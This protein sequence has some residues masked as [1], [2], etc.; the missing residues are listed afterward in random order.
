MLGTLD[1]IVS[2]EAFLE[3]CFNVIAGF[4]G[5]RPLYLD[6]ATPRRPTIGYGFNLTGRSVLEAVATGMGFDL[7]SEADQGYLNE[8]LSIFQSGQSLVQI[9]TQADS[10]M[11]ERADQIVGGARRTFSF[12]AGQVGLAEMRGAFDIA[13]LNYVQIAIDRT[14]FSETDYSWELVALTSLAYNG[15]GGII[16]RGLTNAILTD[17][18]PLAWY[19]IRYRSNAE[20]DFGLQNRREHEADLFGLYA[21]SGTLVSDI[22]AKQ[23]FQLFTPERLTSIAQYISSLNHKSP[24]GAIIEAVT[25]AEVANFLAELQ[26][27]LSP[28]LEFLVSTHVTNPLAGLVAIDGVILVGDDGINENFASTGG[29]LRGTD[30]SDL[31]FG[32]GGVDTVRGGAGVDVAYGG[33][34]SDILYGGDSTD[35]LFGEAD[36][37][38]LHG[39]NGQDQLEGGEGADFLFGGADSDDQFGGGGDDHLYGGTLLNGEHVDDRAIDYF[40]G[41]AGADSIYAWNNDVILNPDASDRVYINGSA[42]PLSLDPANIEAIAGRPG[43]FRDRTSG[44]TFRWTDTDADGSR[45]QLEIFGSYVQ[46]SG[47]ENGD[48]G[49]NLADG[50]PPPPSSVVLATEDADVIG[51]PNGTEAF[52]G[53]GGNDSISAKYI[54][55]VAGIIID[56]GDGDD[57]IRADDTGSY[58]YYHDHAPAPTEDVI[59]HGAYL[60]GGSGNDNLQ[61]SV[62]EDFIDGGVGHD[63]VY[64]YFGDDVVLTGDG[65]DFISGH[66]GEDV[67]FGDAGEDELFGGQGDDVIFGGD[68][69]DRMYGDG[70][71]EAGR[72][73]GAT[74]TYTVVGAYYP[75]PNSYAMFRDVS[76]AESGADTIK[77]GAGIDR[78]YGGAG[79]DALFGGTEGDFLFG[80]VGDDALYG[81][82]GNDVLWG[83]ISPYEYADDQRVLFVQSN[84]DGTSVDI[85]FRRYAQSLD[86]FGND[87]LDG[88]DGDDQI[89]GQGGDDILLGGNGNDFL[90]GD[91]GN[92]VLV[93]GDNDDQLSGDA[94]TDTL[95]GENGVDVLFGGAD[96]DALDGGVGADQLVGGDGLDT[97]NGGDDADVLFGEAGDDQLSGS[98]GNDQLVA[99]DGNDTAAGDGG[100]DVL[101]GDAG[102]DELRGGSGNDQLQGGTGLDS[103]Y[104][105]DGTDILLG[106]ADADSLF[107]GAGIDDL[108]GGA[109]NDQLFG[110]ADADELYG[111]DGDD[112]L[113]GDGGDDLLLGDAGM[114][115]LFGGEGA[116]QLQGAE[117]NDLLD[118]GDGT[119][120]LFGQDGMDV[121][122]GGT[123]TDEMIGGN[124]DD[125]YRFNVGDGRDTI[126][127]SS[128]S[129][130]DVIELGS[131]IS[132]ADVAIA[133]RGGSL[134]LFMSGGNDQ[135]TIANWFSNTSTRV[136]SVGFA[137]GTVWTQSQ[138]SSLPINIYLGTSGSDIISDGIGDDQVLGYEGD[139]TLYGNY[140]INQIVGGTGNDTLNLGY[141]GSNTVSIA[142]GDGNDTIV[143]AGDSYYSV[144][145]YAGVSATELQYDRSGNN[146]VI[147][148]PDGGQTVV[149]GWF[150]GQMLDAIMF[151]DGSTAPSAATISAVAENASRNYAVAADAPTQVLDDWG[152]TDS[153]TFGAGVTP[154]QLTM[155]RQGVDLVVRRTDGGTTQDLVRVPF[156]F[157]GANRQIEEFRFTDSATVFT[158]AA[159]TAQLLNPVGTPSADIF[160][161]GLGYVETLSGVGGN[162]DLTG[163]GNGY[164]LLGGDGDDTLTGNGTGAIDGGN[165][166]DTLYG[167][168]DSNSLR[169]G[170]GND[171]FCIDGDFQ[172]ATGG[173]G[174]DTFENYG[175]Y[176]AYTFN[177]GDGQDVIATHTSGSYFGSGT[178]VLGY[179]FTETTFTNSGPDKILTFAGSSDS[180]R[181]VN[182]V[183]AS[184]IGTFRYT[185]TGT[186]GNDT[187]VGVDSAVESIYGLG[188]DDV[189]YGGD[190]S[191][192][193]SFEVRDS[194]YGGD[195]NDYL[196]GGRE[197]DYLDGGAGN[198]TLGGGSGSQDYEWYGNT[199]RGGAGDDALRGTSFDDIYVYDTG[200]GND[201]VTE[202]PR[203]VSGGLYRSGT[204]RINFG[205]GI[206]P[207]VVT[208]TKSG[209]DLLLQ[210]GSTGS[211]TFRAWFSSSHNQ[212]EGFYFLS[213]G[214]YQLRLTAA[215]VTGMALT[216]IGTAGTDTLVGDAAFG[217]LLYGNGG[218]DTLTGNGGSDYLDGGTGDDTLQGGAGDDI[219]IFG[220]GYGRDLVT[221]EPSDYYSS[222]YNNDEVRF[223]AD[224][225]ASEI[226][227]ARQGNSLLLSIS[228]TSDAL[229]MQDGLT[230][231][232]S[233]IERFVFADGSQLPS[234]DQMIASLVNV[235]GTA[236]DDTLE[237]SSGFDNIRGLEGNDVLR[238]YADND[239]L[240][241]GAGNDSLSGGAGNDTLMGGVGDDRYVYATGDGSDSVQDSLGTNILDFSGADIAS[242][243]V[244][245]SWNGTVNSLT[246]GFASGSLQVASGFTEADRQLLVVPGGA[247]VSFV[248]WLAQRQA[249][250]LVL[251]HAGTD[252]ADQMIGSAGGDSMLGGFGDDTLRGGAGN[253]SLN[254]GW[255][256]DRLEGGTGNDTLVG[257]YG[258]DE[259]VFESGHGLDYV[260]ESVMTEL[261]NIRFGGNT[262]LADLQIARTGADLILLNTRTNDRVTVSGYEVNRSKLP[263]DLYIGSDFISSAALVGQSEVLGTASANTLRG[264]SGSDRIYGLA[265]NDTLE[266][267]AGADLLSGGA[268]NDRLL[269]G[270]GAD[271]YM[272]S[273]G[274]GADTL[275]E[276]GTNDGAVDTVL[277]GEGVFLGDLRFARSGTSLAVSTISGPDGLMIEGWYSNTASQVERFR[278]FQGNVLLNTQVEQ[279]VQAA[280]AFVPKS[281]ESSAS[282]SASMFSSGDWLAASPF[283]FHGGKLDPT[284]HSV[285]HSRAD[286]Y[287]RGLPFG[288]HS[289]L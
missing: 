205:V 207:A 258:V 164:T 221:G 177:R 120:V 149:S 266:G 255:Q 141:Y 128:D 168:G 69:E 261:S 3:A 122:A 165:G 174:N 166:N 35:Y 153:V 235:D 284:A 137:D 158:A 231:T 40:D 180:I 94:G 27:D 135:L 170:T 66:E 162:D 28:A 80:E 254:G 92:D 260:Y 167:I 144:L 15:G 222:S 150:S 278:D 100:D 102:D 214:Q 20:K 240:D 248:D 99:G 223:S 259:F 129:Q 206:D 183:N 186:S 51:V 280:A 61:G 41:G 124:G 74:G 155:Q 47:F 81:D 21:V 106:E 275:S 23:I 26:N 72:W 90:Y 179:A 112:I 131:G 142:A 118:G 209:S 147:T 145:A 96:D 54:A 199:Y 105:D 154:E 288:R 49:I 91:V 277:F 283:N 79:D 250:G 83:D 271:M 208:A 59:A 78:L 173:A 152:G 157:D 273:Q 148:R 89:L 48:L 224:L 210:L 251:T 113:N 241:G 269:G 172:S 4:E 274:W 151:S 272:L 219:Y 220:T 136:S 227:V 64:A 156:W 2:R 238:G 62:R 262:S 85:F 53:L 116:D 212:V 18:R 237:G 253:D 232:G 203:L 109:G 216:Q 111:E 93:G 119:D 217:D 239:T 204:D 215:D 140:G 192:P 246:F 257:G 228:G 45:D 282:R 5:G 138:I 195:G 279:L 193:A 43:M 230:P 213:D 75:G 225:S 30:R 285:V 178:L 12:S 11:A 201:T 121:L 104:G 70:Q 127:E 244:S 42:T 286:A 270:A 97:L 226:G 196:D 46:V 25:D 182:Q 73:V 76:E 175:Q 143:N 188:G 84:S 114:D 44:I 33:A 169:G 289:S 103:L 39:E 107:G 249:A 14:E 198:D 187:L 229:T 57:V 9:Q 101:F 125:V 132:P 264:G 146:L 176:T 87:T 160:T 242:A 189:L 86:A 190:H 7:E 117:G 77:G 24:T 29:E 236:A 65:S 88:G 133:Q 52:Y 67:L 265:G 163:N 194:L 63:S 1:S 191:A 82:E 202:G 50:P 267:K 243:P 98:S 32:E 234:L 276:A 58:N 38:Y 245:V 171:A 110:G 108:Q 256:N 36:N 34:D 10:V 22:E 134:T 159:I 161:S 6:N 115:Q 263:L 130:G 247:Q 17:D 197:S 281:A 37:D 233:R 13:I 268:G 31:I 68:G 16:G 55:D 126:F 139:D 95:F 185:I 200:D 71:E 123:G 252:Y 287:R 8:L 181:L 19:E 184:V 211:I 218:N 60:F 56:G